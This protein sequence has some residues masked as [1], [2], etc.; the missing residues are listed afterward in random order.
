MSRLLIGNFDF[1]W[2][3]ARPQ[4]TPAAAQLRLCDEL[5]F[6]WLAFAEPDDVLLIPGDPGPEFWS[7]LEANLKWSLPSVVKRIEDAPT[8]AIVTPWGWT[9]QLITACDRAGLQ[10]PQHP[11]PNIVRHVNSRR[12]S[13]TL[14]HELQSA[15]EWSAWLEST[16]QLETHLRRYTQKNSYGE[17]WLAKSD[18]SNSTRERLIGSGD[19]LTPRDRAWIDTR[20]TR[21]GGLAFE[22]WLEIVD[23]VSF[24]F[25]I[26][27]SGE[28]AL[29]GLTPLVTDAAGHYRGNLFA[30]TRDLTEQWRSELDVAT[31]AAQ[32]IAA[33]GYFG[34]LGIDASR[35]HDNDSPS[36]SRPLQ[37]INARYTM[38]R[39][40]L[41]WRRLT[42]RHETG[43][44]RH[45]PPS[46]T[47]RQPNEPQALMLDRTIPTSPA[48]L[49]GRP[50]R[51]QHRVEIGAASE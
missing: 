28:I 42:T 33:E 19:T 32:R 51:I 30:G 21:D 31:S 5:A 13:T 43:H 15:P 40:S 14:E 8:G 37:D 35:Y 50:T 16:D 36:R 49:D 48:M 1:E 3:L 4:S 39:L 2:S 12:F 20:I 7:V 10:L 34:P 27:S 6:T 45:G 46:A 23:E 25:D 22:P 17:R 24:Q 18:L 26:D 41:G 11:A 44:W 47:L 9:P 38:G 29:V